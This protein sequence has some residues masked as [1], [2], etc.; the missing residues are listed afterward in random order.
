MKTKPV[1]FGLLALFGVQ[2]T[3]KE[4]RSSDNM[5]R[6]GLHRA[7]LLSL[8]SKLDRKGCGWTVLNTEAASESCSSC[9]TAD[10]A[11]LSVTQG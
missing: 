5:S 10:V 1:V 4:E 6:R 3:S 9:M 8:Q 7:R 11:K 2:S